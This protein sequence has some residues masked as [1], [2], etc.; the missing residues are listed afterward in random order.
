MKRPIY[1]SKLFSTIMFEKL[2]D[3]NFFLIIIWKFIIFRKLI[4]LK[5]YIFQDVWFLNNNNLFLFF[6]ENDVFFFQITKLY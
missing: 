1:P 2:F 5:I 4:F 6:L 3:L